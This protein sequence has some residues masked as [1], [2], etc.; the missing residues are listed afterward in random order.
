MGSAWYY[1][2]L[3]AAALGEPF[4]V[5]PEDAPKTRGAA[6]GKSAQGGESEALQFLLGFF[7]HDA[8]QFAL[9]HVKA[10]ENDLSVD[11]LYRVAAAL[12]ATGQYQE[13]M[14]LVSLYCGRGD[15]QIRRRDLEL[16]HPRPFREM[17]ERY[18]EETGLEPSLLFG[19]IRTESAFNSGVVS[20]AGA[21]GLT[22]LM[23]ATAD[24]MAV[25]I[26][27]RGGPNYIFT[28]VDESNPVPIDLRNPAVNI[29]IGAVYLA[30]LNERMEDTLTALLAYNGGMNR[31]RRWRRANNL[32]AGNL[33]PDLFLETVDY[34]ETR[35]YGR[36]VMGSAAVYKELYY[37]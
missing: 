21:V 30:Y 28:S 12:G 8:A 20:R 34:A 22:Q 2:S 13:S 26:R 15:Y 25:L 35:N 36:S 9:R 5:V 32:S 17:V 3:A 16:L 1:R 7:E 18:A 29:H 4:L 11:E 10:M 24:E 19:L 27:R 33:P 14:R 23:P 37:K 31:V 6:Q